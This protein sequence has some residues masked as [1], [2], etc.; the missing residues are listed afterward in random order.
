MASLT[1]AKAEPNQEATYLDVY[2]VPCGAQY[3]KRFRATKYRDGLLHDVISNNY[4]WILGSPR[5]CAILNDVQTNIKAFCQ[6]LEEM[7]FP[8]CPDI[9]KNY[10]LISVSH[11]LDCLDRNS[12]ALTW[13]DSSRDNLRKYKFLTLMKSQI[14]LGASFFCIARSSCVFIVSD[15]IRDKILEYKVTGLAFRKCEIIN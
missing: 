7:D 5:L 15:S 1:L 6:T 2:E 3:L 13:F 11:V 14:P 10:S 4:G 9:I 12:A 8:P